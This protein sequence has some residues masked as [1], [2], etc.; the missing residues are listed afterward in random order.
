MVDKHGE[1]RIIIIDKKQGGIAISGIVRGYL[2]Q[3]LY[4]G[5]TAKEAKIMFRR[6]AKHKK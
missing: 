2:M 5:Y 4:I 6:E 3:R 1:V